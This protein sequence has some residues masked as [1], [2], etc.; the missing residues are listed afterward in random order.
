MFYFR[1]DE[2]IGDE[3]IIGRDMAQIRTRTNKETTKNSK[4]NVK[5]TARATAK[6]SLRRNGKNS[7]NHAV[8]GHGGRGRKRTPSPVTNAATNSRNGNSRG[9]KNKKDNGSEKMDAISEGLCK[10]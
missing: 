9:C 3:R 10:E 7:A 6:H 2:W 4:V 8:K 5:P 1:H